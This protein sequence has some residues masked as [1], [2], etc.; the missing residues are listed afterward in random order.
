MNFKFFTTLL[1]VTLSLFCIPLSFGQLSFGQLSFEQSVPQEQKSVTL[2][3][4][5]KLACDDNDMDGI[6]NEVDLD[7]D[8]DGILDTD[9]GDCESIPLGDVYIN[10]ASNELATYNLD[11]GTVNVICPNLSFTAGDIGIAP[12]G[13]IYMVDPS[14]RLIKVDPANCAETVIG[15]LP[16][17]AVNSLTFLPDGTALAGSGSSN[18]IYRVTISPFSVAVWATIPNFTSSGDFVQIDGKIYYLARQ[19]SILGLTTSILEITIDANYDYISYVDLGSLPNIAYGATISRNCQLVWGADD[20]IY[21]INDI[22]TGNLESTTI[23]TSIPSLGDIFGFS[24]LQEVSGCNSDCIFITDTD[25]DGILNIYDLD[26]D[27]DGCSDANEYYNSN[28]ADGSDTGVFGP[29]PATVDAN[30]LVITASYTGDYSTAITADFNSSVCS[31]PCDLALPGNF[32]TDNDGL[33]DECDLDA[34]NDGITNVEEGYCVENLLFSF[35]IGNEGWIEDNTN[36]GNFQSPLVNSSG[37]VTDSG[38]SIAGLPAGPSGNYAIMSDIISSDMFFESPDNLNLSLS[39]ATTFSFYWLDGTF[40]GTGTPSSTTLPVILVGGGTSITAN[41]SGVSNNGWQFISIPLDDAN[42]SGTQ[43]DLNTVLADLDRI[44][45]EVEN[46]NGRNDGFCALD[47]Y[48]GIDEVQIACTPLDTDGDGVL[49]YLDLDSDNDGCPDAIEGGGSFVDTDLTNDALCPNDPTCVDAD[50]V[51]LVASGGQ[52]VGSSR[53]VSIQAPDCSFIPSP[54]LVCESTCATVGSNLVPNPDLETPN[55]V[56]CNNPGINGEIYL[57][58]SAIADWIGAAL[59]TGSNSGITPDYLSNCPGTNA[60][61]PNP[62]CGGQALGFF[63]TA[64][65]AAVL[66]WVQAPLISQLESGADYCLTFDAFSSDFGFT[67]ADGLSVIVIDQILDLDALGGPVPYTPVYEH[68]SGDIIPTTCNTYNTTFTALGTEQWIAFGNIDPLSTILDGGTFASTSYVIID[69]ISLR[70]I[71][72]GGFQVSTIQDA[73]SCENGSATAV[74]NGG[75]APYTYQWSDGQTT[76][77]ATFPDNG[78]YTVTVTDVNG[79]EDFSTVNITVSAP[80]SIDLLETTDANCGSADGTISVTTV[81]G[82]TSPYL[83]D[84][85]SGATASNTETGLAAGAYT[86]T[87]TDAN[88]CV[89]TSSVTVSGSTQLNFTA[90]TNEPSCNGSSDGSINL[91]IADGTPPYSYSWSSGPTSGN[92]TGTI[93]NNLFAGSYTIQLTDVNGCNEII[94]TSISEPSAFEVSTNTTSLTCNGDTDGSIELLGTDAQNYSYA[95]DNGQDSGSGTGAVIS[96]LS[97]GQYDIQITNTDGCSTSILASLAEPEEI[98]VSNV[99]TAPACVGSNDGTIELDINTAESYSYTWTNGLLS[100]SGTETLIE[101]LPSGSYTIEIIIGDCSATTFATLVE[102]TSIDLSVNVSSSTC[103]NDTDGSIILNSDN[104]VIS[105]YIWDNGMDSES[106][107]GSV[108]ENLLPGNYSIEVTDENGCTATVSAV[109]EAI[110]EIELTLTSISAACDVPDNTI[111]INVVNYTQSYSYDWTNGMDSGSGSSAF[112]FGLDSG[113]Y[114][115]TLTD[116]VGCTATADIIIDPT[117]GLSLQAAP[118]NAICENPGS[119]ELNIQSGTPGYSYEWSNGSDIGNGM[120][121]NIADLPAGN[122]TITITDNEGCTEITS[123]VI[124]TIDNLELTL[125]PVSDDCGGADNFISLDVTNFD[126][127]YS[128]SWDNGADTGNGSD[129]DITNLSPGTYSV[130]VTDNLG[131]EASAVTIIEPSLPLLLSASSV[132]VLCGVLGSIELDIQNGTPVYSYEWL[133]GNDSGSGSGTSITD[134]AAGEYLITVT[135]GLGCSVETGIIVE[136]LEDIGIAIQTDSINCNIGQ[137]EYSAAPIG[138]TAPYTY[139][140]SNGQTGAMQA[141]SFSDTTS[142]IVTITDA[143]DCVANGTIT[144]SDAVLDSD[145]DGKVDECDVCPDL[146]NFLIGTSCDD[147]D[148]LTVNDVYT[149]ECLCEGVPTCVTLDLRVLLEGA[150][151]PVAGEMITGLNNDRGLLPGQTPTGL[152]PP[153]PAGQ[154]Y[155]KAPW[156]Y[157]GTEGAGWTGANYIDEI[158]DW[159]LVSFRTGVSKNTESA[160]GAGLLYEDGTISFVNDCVLPY[161]EGADSAYVVIEHRNHMGVMTPTAIQLNEYTLNYDFT[162]Q[163]SYTD[164][165]GLG[166]GQVQFSDGKWGM[167]GGDGDQSDFPSYDINALDKAGWQTMN[168]SFDIYD[169]MDFNM[170]GDVNGDDKIIWQK[171]NGFSSRVPK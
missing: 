157:F 104:A 107:T 145:G 31:A 86:V 65:A 159:V 37:G 17:I 93:I 110:P 1:V 74:V 12:D 124:E 94:S 15:E 79:C 68:P 115:F 80:P 129:S 61:V 56:I 62:G 36:N 150:Y 35:E 160:I 109:I 78:L 169:S 91:N 96:N 72:S 49:D 27:N 7:D 89:A 42:W 57:D 147:G 85:G 84:F 131:C 20:A 127:S 88:N 161:K 162:V 128:Y 166:V 48:Y 126:Q 136:E 73:A 2:I 71:E 133:N 92:G 155:D 141:T 137:V 100:G 143:N 69:N 60:G 98:I 47:E 41:F 38:C 22:T 123:A 99:P 19:L 13:E 167:Y 4:S 158:V 44:E 3:T 70:K 95:W 106:G 102:P 23:T 33:A 139:L 105:S 165:L 118:T 5:S 50:G 112:L 8:N 11:N 10:T 164:S 39:G 40:D 153:T 43:A 132:D 154:P 163:D 16:F 6:C 25:G 76:A 64:P 138:G 125:I 146:N 59:S 21:V 28:T 171:N 111:L 14:G 29:D 34:D 82:G 113:N 119:I 81:L 30:G 45:I 32:D 142:Y 130:T 66:E 103:A 168:G 55:P 101:N 67:P 120:G 75:N 140:W 18:D 117:V 122:Y 83:Y 114:S 149:I 90:I 134:L 58:Y 156:F 148:S 121:T 152:T 144:P 151:D 54:N 170:N 53:D 9:E 46:I 77:A 116:A 108:I 97:A 51:P 135:D 26:S 87:V 63:T 52:N 24:S